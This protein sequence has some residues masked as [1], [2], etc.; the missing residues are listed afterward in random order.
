LRLVTAVR[1]LGYSCELCVIKILS[2]VS[3]KRAVARLKDPDDGLFIDPAYIGEDLKVV[4]YMALLES[5]MFDK[6]SIFETSKEPNGAPKL[7]RSGVT[8]RPAR[9]PS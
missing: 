9:M 5:N 6:W 7:L 2:L 3:M 4:S 1:W 8:K